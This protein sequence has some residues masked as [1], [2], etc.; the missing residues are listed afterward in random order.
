M[1]RRLF[2]AHPA[3]VNETYLQH[4]REALSFA[5]PLLAAGVAA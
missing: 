2:L 1:F 4:Q 3:S 5:L